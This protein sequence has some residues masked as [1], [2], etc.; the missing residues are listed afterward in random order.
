M[1]D[2]WWVMPVVFLTF[3]AIVLLVIAGGKMET[4]RIYYNCL[5]KNGSMVYTDAVK[6]CKEI[7]K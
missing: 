1:N 3:A 4:S 7:V 5:D 6:H 2:N